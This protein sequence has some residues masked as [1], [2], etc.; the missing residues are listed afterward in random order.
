M[1]KFAFAFPQ[2][3]DLSRRTIPLHLGYYVAVFLLF[4][5]CSVR[6]YWLLKGLPFPPYQDSIRDVGFINGILAGNLF[7]DPTNLGAMRWYPPLLHFI[8][9]A[10]AGFTDTDTIKLWMAVAPLLNLLAPGSFFLLSKAL[11]GIRAATLATFAFVLLNGWLTPPWVTATY[12]PWP[13][14]P[15]LA[16]ALFFTTVLIIHRRID[17]ARYRDA[18]VIGVAIGLTFLAH[19]IPGLILIPVV[20]LAALIVQGPN[21]RTLFWLMVAGMSAA[22]PA[23]LY[24]GPLIVDYRLD[25]LNFVP[26]IIT[27]RM[28][29]P[30]GGRKKILAAMHLP[31]FV[32]LIAVATLVIRGFLDWQKISLGPKVTAILGAWILA[33]IIALARQ[34]ACWPIPNGYSICDTFAVPIHHFHVYLQAAEAILIGHVVCLIYER[35]FKRVERLVGKE[36]WAAV[37]I[38]VVLVTAGCINFLL[39]PSDRDMLERVEKSMFLDFELYQWVI[40]NSNQ[41]D[42]FVTDLPDEE[43]DPAA[44]AV[45]AG[46]R[47]LVAAPAVQSNPFLNWEERNRRR[48]NY[49]V[50][51]ITESDASHAKLCRLVQEAGPGSRAYVVIPN[52]LQASSILGYPLFRSRT[53]AV[54]LV[55]LSRIDDGC[56]SDQR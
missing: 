41:G 47:R 32:A 30:G 35:F 8:F 11:V 28:F 6:G 53:N 26:V 4:C 49:Y 7:G 13:Y 1:F 45:F 16:E 14:T 29:L 25:V 9:A 22:A 12:A 54:Y 55:D 56:A 24:L 33:C 5:F 46:A 36:S 43:H 27:E 40:A 17:S 52:N 50:A 34:F 39:R 18:V 2:V 23:L 3:A 38:S 15:I 20:T 44:F 19:T 48:N 37:A 21:V 31:T 10:V 42:L 51:A